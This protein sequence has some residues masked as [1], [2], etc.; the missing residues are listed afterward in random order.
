MAV[1]LDRTKIPDA[2]EI[3]GLACDL[4][5]ALHGTAD[6]DDLAFTGGRGLR[7]RAQA[8]HV[9][10]KGGNGDP[11]WRAA[12]ELG[13]T[14]GNVS[15]GGRAPL[16]ECVGGVPDQRETAL[17]DD[18]TQLGFIGRWADDGG[19]IDLPIPG[20]K[21]AAERGADDETVR[22]RDRMGHGY[23]FYVEWTERESTPERHDVHR[24]LGRTWLAFPLGL[25]QRSGK[26]R[27]VDWQLE[28]RPQVEQRA[29]MILVRV[30][31]HTA[32][33]MGAPLLQ[34]ADVRHDEIDA[35]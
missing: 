32:A 22:F 34:I 9:R 26:R 21:H 35:G 28:A 15:F 31:E 33:K 8:R 18:R 29:E 14:F 7:D 10:G 2:I 3:A 12:D 24:D 25:Q 11:R 20:V 6:Q 13:E 17:V 19:R 27:G 5:D 4:R 30:R 1:D 16:A 23:E